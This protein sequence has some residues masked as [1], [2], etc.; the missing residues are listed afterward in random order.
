MPLPQ[1]TLSVIQA[2]GAAVYAADAEL[3]RTVQGY[4]DQVQQAIHQNPFDVGNDTL[5]EDWK[6]AAR[7]SQAMAQ[8]EKELQGI[9]RAAQ[10][11]SSGALAA[12]TR[13]VP[14]LGA[15]MAASPGNLEMVQEIEATDVAVKKSRKRSKPKAR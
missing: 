2:A 3:K 9:Y 8:V 13:G 12:D 4:A 14:A 15:P 5:F 1:T 7:L 10:E 11:W 6:T